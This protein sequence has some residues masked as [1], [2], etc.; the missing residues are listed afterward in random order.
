MRRAAPLSLSGTA[1]AAAAAAAAPLPVP[2]ECQ[3]PGPA[4][5]RSFTGTAQ[6]DLAYQDWA[7]LQGRGP[8]TAGG[9]GCNRHWHVCWPGQGPQ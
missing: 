5:S 6:L 4:I 9:Y 3:W 8:H 2:G 7:R 1:A